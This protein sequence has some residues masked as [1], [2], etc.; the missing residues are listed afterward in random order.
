MSVKPSKSGTRQQRVLFAIA[1]A[2]A[3]LAGLAGDVGDN[4]PDLADCVSERLW[5][6]LE[7]AIQ[8]IDGEL[9]QRAAES[10]LKA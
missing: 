3:A 9:A 8:E 7:Q 10:P 1:E 6:D 2:Q 4:T 5:A